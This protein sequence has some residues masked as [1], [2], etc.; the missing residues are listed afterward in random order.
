MKNLSLIFIILLE[1]IIPY[2]VAQADNFDKKG[3]VI[4]YEGKSTELYIE[5]EKNTFYYRLKPNVARQSSLDKFKGFL[6]Y[7]EKDK[8]AGT[9]VFEIRKEKN[10]EKKKNTWQRAREMTVVRDSNGNE[11]L[12]V[13]VSDFGTIKSQL[14]KNQKMK[15]GN[16]YK[17]LIIDFSSNEL[18]GN[19]LK[20]TGQRVGWYRINLTYSKKMRE[21]EKMVRQFESYNPDTINVVKK[22]EGE[23]KTPPEKAEIQEATQE[24]QEATQEVQVAKQEVQAEPEDQNLTDSQIEKAKDESEELLVY[25]KSYAAINRD[26]LDPLELGK[27]F[28]NFKKASAKGWNKKALDK[29]NLLRDYVYS[30][31]TFDSYVQKIKTDELN[32]KKAEIAHLLEGLKT[33]LKILKTFVSDNLG[34]E[35]SFEALALADEIKQSVKQE[36]HEKLIEL[37]K[38]VGDWKSKEIAQ[39]SDTILNGNQSK[40]VISTSTPTQISGNDLPN[41]ENQQPDKKNKKSPVV[42][43]NNEIKSSNLKPITRADYETGY[44]KER[45]NIDICTGQ[46]KNSS[47]KPDP[48]LALEFFAKTENYIESQTMLCWIYSDGICG[49]PKNK[50]NAIKFCKKTF[51]NAVPENKDWANRKIK[52]VMDENEYEEYLEFVSDTN[53]LREEFE[54]YFIVKKCHEVNPLYISASELNKAKKKIRKTDDFYKSKG[55]DTDVIYRNTELY[56]QE[57]IRKILGALELGSVG[58]YQQGFDS[59]CKL[60]FTGMKKDESAKG[61]K[62]F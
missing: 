4:F 38:K 47:T 14:S 29:Y 37:G 13:R 27:L 19:L 49:L 58:G 53:S 56:P 5:V 18:A 57:H 26:D 55:L 35:K 60:Y 20:E 12:K 52:T 50:S 33:D 1:L 51:I 39:G 43:E 31:E 30:S 40:D 54:F 34:T 28:M 16:P 46:I 25:I 17:W 32:K 11:F 36:N 15:Y 10:P 59:S 24:V 61:K 41:N 9:F 48:K 23:T 7:I 45:L 3:S 42:V 6:D 44:K 62:D 22:V 2:S 21:Y 8:N